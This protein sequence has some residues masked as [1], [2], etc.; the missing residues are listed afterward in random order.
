MLSINLTLE[1]GVYRLEFFFSRIPAESNGQLDQASSDPS[2]L[3]SR[4]P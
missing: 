2:D 4:R 1:P 3:G